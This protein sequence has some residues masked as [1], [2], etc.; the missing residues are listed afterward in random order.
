MLWSRKM[1]LEASFGFLVKLASQWEI[2]GN[3]QGGN[4]LISACDQSKLGHELCC[5]LSVVCAS[6]APRSDI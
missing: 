1:A 6:P 3:Q 5:L 4:C 2:Q